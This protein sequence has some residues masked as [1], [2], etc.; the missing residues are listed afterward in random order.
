MKDKRK[1][2][3]CKKCRKMVNINYKKIGNKI[4]FTCPNCLAQGEYRINK[5]I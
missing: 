5:R 2:I 4:L 1:R 3:R